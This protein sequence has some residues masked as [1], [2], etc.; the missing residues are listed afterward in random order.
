MIG[1]NNMKILITGLLII[2]FFCVNIN[3]FADNGIA[4]V[5][6]S[7][8]DVKAK[9]SDEILSLLPGVRLQVGDIIITGSNSRVG[10]IFNDGSVLSLDENSFFRIND[11]VFKP[12]EK[13]FKFNLYL[14]NGAALFESGKIGK[15]APQNFKFEIPEGTIG[16]RGTKF[17]VEV[18]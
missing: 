7:K 1:S 11:F 3:A 10:I 15:L 13:K 2:S 8:G 18:K 5:K 14:E 17:L 4:I 9:R 16:I 12:I 6:S